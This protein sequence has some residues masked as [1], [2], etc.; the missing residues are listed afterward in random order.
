MG[1]KVFQPETAEVELNGNTYQITPQPLKRAMMFESALQDILD[2]WQGTIGGEEEDSFT[3]STIISEAIQAPY[4]LLVITIPDLKKDD[5]DDASWPQISWLFD[6]VLEING[7]TWLK[8]IVKNLS[9]SLVDLA[10]AA[11]LEASA[12]FLRKPADGETD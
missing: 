12:G 6:T 4:E 5:L 9:R 3:F 11:I 8:E 2:R 1:K 10:P 7:F